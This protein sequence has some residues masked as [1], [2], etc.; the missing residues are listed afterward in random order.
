MQRAVLATLVVSLTGVG[1]AHA[2]RANPRDYTSYLNKPIPRQSTQQPAPQINLGD[3]EGGSESDST[4]E[5]A[6]SSAKPES[7]EVSED[8]RTPLPGKPS[9]PAWRPPSPTPEWRPPSPTPEWR[10]PPPTPEWRPPPPTPEATIPA[11][12]AGPHGPHFDSPPDVSSPP[13]PADDVS[14]RAMGAPSLWP[15]FAPPPA[16]NYRFWVGTETLLWWEKDGHLPPN[17]V[18]TGFPTDAHPGALGQPNTLSL[19]GA[20]NLDYGAFGGIRLFGGG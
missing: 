14:P 17:L 6:D 8:S 1:F 16:A 15:A 7:G 19:S 9:Q 13:H 2:Q 10:P 4:A 5:T 12:V 11:S 18:T 20:G 3:V